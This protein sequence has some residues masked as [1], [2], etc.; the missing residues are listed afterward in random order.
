VVDASAVMELLLGTP[1][2]RR[3]SERL[4]TSDEHLCAPHLLDVEVAQVL[5]R[6]ARE[7]VLTPERGQEALRDLSDLPL[8]RYPHE[9]FLGRI[10]ELRDVLTAYDAA[11]V[12]LAEAL[13]V[14]LV[15]CD[16]RIGRASGHQARVET[17]AV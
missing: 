10:W 16:A 8:A 12:A 14:P 17:V 7:G 5:R 13:D 11:Y 15:T 4:L 1:L 2:G 6:Y 3:C 9:P